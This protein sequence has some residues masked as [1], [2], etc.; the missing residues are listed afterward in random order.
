MHNMKKVA[1]SCN[2][3]LFFLNAQC[4]YYGPAVRNSGGF[5]RPAKGRGRSNYVN[6]TFSKSVNSSLALN[7]IQSNY[8]TFTLSPKEIY[9][10]DC[11]LTF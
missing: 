1:F 6:A 11:L 8:Y 7:Y 10:L 9:Y 2:E 5:T 4:K 3:H